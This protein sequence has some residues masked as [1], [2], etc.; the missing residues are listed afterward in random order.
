MTFTIRP[1]IET[2]CAALAAVHIA[3]WNAT[4]QGIVPQDYLDSLDGTSRAVQWKEWLASG[5]TQA[6]IA[7][8]ENNNPAGFIS[9]GTLRTPPPGL[10]PIRPLYSAEIYAIYILPEYWRQ[11]L[12]RQLLR[13][14][15]LKLKDMKHSSLCLWVIEKNHRALDFYKALSG[16]RCGSREIDVGGTKLKELAIGWRKTQPLMTEQTP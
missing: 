3:G 1:A 16:E 10:S 2:D 13:A 6:L 8:D 11:G 14:A 5:Q 4:Y 12:G 15:A 7:H 9:F